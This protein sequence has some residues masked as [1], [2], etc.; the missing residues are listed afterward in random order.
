[1]MG[2]TGTL[3]DRVLESKGVEIRHRVEKIA[4]VSRRSM[5]SRWKVGDCKELAH[6]YVVSPGFGVGDKL[7][8]R[9]VHP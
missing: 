7:Q 9:T 1:M 6:I 5:L 3:V 8:W 4:W 2:K